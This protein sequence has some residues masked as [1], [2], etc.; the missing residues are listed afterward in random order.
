MKI[1]FLSLLL[2]SIAGTVSAAVHV[3]IQEC[4]SD[5]TGTKC[6]A[7]PQLTKDQCSTEGVSLKIE[8]CNRCGKK[9][10]VTNDSV[11][12]LTG[13]AVTSLNGGNPRVLSLPTGPLDPGRC[14]EAEFD[15]P[16]SNCKPFFN[17]EV[18]VQTRPNECRGYYFDRK[19]KSIC[20]TGGTVE[21][22]TQG[23]SCENFK[24]P[25]ITY[26]DDV[27]SDFCPKIECINRSRA[28]CQKEVVYD[29][30]LTNNNDQLVTF[31]LTPPE[32][33]NSKVAWKLVEPNSQN[34]APIS[35]NNKRSWTERKS[36]NTC[37]VIPAASINVRGNVMGKKETTKKDPN[38]KFC[39]KFNSFKKKN[40]DK[41]DGSKYPHCDDVRP[42]EVPCPTPPSPAGA[43]PPSKGTGSPSKGKGKG[44]GGPPPPP[45]KCFCPQ[46]VTSSK[47]DIDATTAD[48]ND[49]L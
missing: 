12:N 31:D 29:F 13:G 27:I 9:I 32:I 26:T 34:F 45:P 7:I 36:V 8:Y 49:E 5:T 48:G 30:D 21:C 6:G 11:V 46:V 14:R 16:I 47:S 28:D 23:Q 17:V 18:I 19:M 33:A 20:K 43:L 24:P 38:Y 39:F 2:T 35:G 1:G 44:K 22:T 25:I 40:F 15:F 41:P 37:R 42:V 3:N 10:T 4:E